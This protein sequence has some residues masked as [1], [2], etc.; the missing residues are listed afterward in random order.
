M[1]TI[2]HFGAE[3]GKLFEPGPRYATHPFEIIAV[4]ASV[5]IPVGAY[6]AEIKENAIVMQGQEEGCS[7]VTTFVGPEEEIARVIPFIYYYMTQALSPSMLPAADM[8]VY[9]QAVLAERGSHPSLACEVPPDF[10]SEELHLAVL[11]GCGITDED[12]FA[13]GLTAKIPAIA[14]AAMFA[15]EPGVSFISELKL[16][17]GDSLLEFIL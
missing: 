15:E 3:D 14:V 2:D 12:D 4:L 5:F 16:L 17:N 8:L 1:I 9:I 7:T 6:F 11:H 10:E 13:A